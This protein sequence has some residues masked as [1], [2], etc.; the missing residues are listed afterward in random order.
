MEKEENVYAGA[1]FVDLIKFNV[2]NLIRYLDSDFYTE[3]IE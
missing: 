1:D 2:F 3:L